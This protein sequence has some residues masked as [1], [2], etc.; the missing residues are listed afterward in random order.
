MRRLVSIT[1]LVDKTSH[2]PRYK[3][4]SSRKKRTC[5]MPAL[6]DM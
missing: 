2:L 5:S 1:G 3:L 4:L 6:T